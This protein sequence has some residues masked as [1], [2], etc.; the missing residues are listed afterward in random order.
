LTK[1]LAGFAAT[2]RVGISGKG[3]SSLVKVRK[4]ARHPGCA[5]Y[6]ILELGTSGLFPYASGVIGFLRFI[7]V[8]NAAVWLGTAIFFTFGAGPACLSTDLKTALGLAAGDSY[9]PGAIEAIMM[10][11][12]YH[13]SLACAVIALLHLLTEWLY[14]GRP[15]RK[16]SFGLLAGLFILTF[17]GSNLLQPQLHDLNRKRF[18]P[19]QPA[20]HESSAKSMRIVSD[21]AMAFNVLIIGGLVIYVWRVANPSDTL[22]FV[23]PVKF[24]S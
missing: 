13:L 20:A 3:Q 18:S 11:R 2:G 1:P 17:I 10:A 12:Y 4:A 24:R 19:T 8:M 6:W 22:R 9:P 5:V 15:G 23:S 14:M 16:F 7:G 21:F